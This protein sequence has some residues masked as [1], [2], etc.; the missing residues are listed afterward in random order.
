MFNALG[1]SMNPMRLHSRSLVIDSHC[2]TLM[3]VIE[4]EGFNL[5]NEHAEGHVDIPRLQRGGVGLQFFAAYIEPLY[6]PLGATRRTLQYL[7]GFYRELRANPDHLHHVLSAADIAIAR[8]QG[9][10][11]A[12]FS[13]EGG[14][15]LEGDLAVLRMFYRLGVRSIGLTWNERNQIAEGVGDSRSQGGLTTFGVSVIAEM[16]RLGMLIDVSHLSKPGFMDVLANSTHPVIASHSNARAVCDHVRNLDDEQIIALAAREGVMGMNFAP[17]FLHDSGQASI[18][19]V[20]DHM[21]H[22]ANLVGPRHIGIGSDFDGIA[23]TPVGLEDVS[24]LQALTEAMLSR[25]FSESEVSSI[26]G[27]NYLRVLSAVLR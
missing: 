11:G 1:A 17:I 24:K 3:R 20:V 13:I 27:G 26:L 19:H 15:A 9:K 23:T 6:K 21:V 5:A 10:I 12:L 22:I 4:N 2:D 25:G 7:D 14:E 8:S 16:N 18:E